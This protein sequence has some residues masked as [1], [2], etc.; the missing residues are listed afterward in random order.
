MAANFIVKQP[1][2]Y[3][4]RYQNLAWV[5]TGTVI[6]TGFGVGVQ[7]IR[8]CAQTAGYCAIDNLGTVPTTAGGLGMF[9]PNSTVGGEY[10]CVRPGEIFSWSSTSTSSGVISVTEMA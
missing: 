4:V 7:H 6:S 9:I 3:P 10:F 8:V 2:S 5:G 1:A